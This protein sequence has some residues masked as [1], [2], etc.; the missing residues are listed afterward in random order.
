MA[1]ETEKVRLM[2]WMEP[3]LKQRID[4]AAR[5]NRRSLTAELCTLAEEA[6]AKR[7]KIKEAVDG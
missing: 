3:E 6:L 1:A 7:P 2:V 5:N 4:E